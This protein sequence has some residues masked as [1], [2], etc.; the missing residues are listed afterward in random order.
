MTKRNVGLY[1][2]FIPE[3]TMEDTKN[4]SAKS[5]GYWKDR[6]DLIIQ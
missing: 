3:W 6:V 4:Y 1:L 2:I 5:L